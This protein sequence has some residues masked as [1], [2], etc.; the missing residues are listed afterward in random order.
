M[1]KQITDYIGKFI[2]PFLFGEGKVFSTQYAFLLL[3]ESSRLCLVLEFSYFKE[4]HQDQF[5]VSYCLTFTST[6]YFFALPK[7]NICNFAD[8]INPDLKSEKLERN[9]E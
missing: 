6:I 9:S 7:I 3:I 8:D 2:L 4:F 5:L 1:Q